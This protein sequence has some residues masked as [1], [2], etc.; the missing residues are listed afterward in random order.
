VTHIYGQGVVEEV[1]LP[2]GSLFIAAGR[3][4]FVAHDGFCAALSA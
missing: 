4:D 2:D 1:R 3:V